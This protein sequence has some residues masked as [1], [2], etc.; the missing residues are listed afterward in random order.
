MDD[1]ELHGL[2][3][4]LPGSPSASQYRNLARTLLPYIG[5]HVPPMGEGQSLE[6][7]RFLAEVARHDLGLAR[8]IEGHLDATQILHEA[9]RQPD[10]GALYGIWASGGPDDTTHFMQTE[11]SGGCDE[12]SGRK[13]FC[14]GSDIVDRALVYVYPSEQLVDIDMQAAAA[15]HRL[16]FDGEHWKAPAFA[17]THTWTVTFDRLPLGPGQSI[18]DQRWY[19]ERPG[20]CLGALAPAACWAG[21]ANGLVD[22]I[23]RKTLKGGHAKVHLGAMVA[24]AQ[25]SQAMLKWGAERIDA[26]PANESGHMFATA[27]LVRH[28]IERNCTEILDRFGRALGPRPF[29]FDEVNA[30]RTTE[31]QLYIRQCHAESDLEELGSHL[32]AHRDFP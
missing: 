23:R 20:F 1:P 18:D 31:L 8:I 32:A 22:H 6:R 9:Q 16:R 30:R 21:G 13:P 29:A 10:P 2:L 24:A 12:L 17:E 5:N 3:S 4:D 25:S 26:D 19:F 27:L 14:S 11:T 7:L 28:L 15:E